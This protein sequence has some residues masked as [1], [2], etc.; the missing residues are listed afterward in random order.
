MGYQNS[1]GVHHKGIIVGQKEKGKGRKAVTAC[2]MAILFT[3]KNL[4]CMEK[5]QKPIIQSDV[6]R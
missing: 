2:C 6:R 1:V 4:P 5:R 3:K